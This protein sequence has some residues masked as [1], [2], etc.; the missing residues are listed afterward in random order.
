MD[1]R[2]PSG[3]TLLVLSTK[4]ATRFPKTRWKMQFF[5]QQAPSGGKSGQRR[6]KRPG[7]PSSSDKT[8]RLCLR[9]QLEGKEWLWSCK[10]PRELLCSP[11][12]FTLR[13]PA[14]HSWHPEEPDVEKIQQSFH[15]HKAHKGAQSEITFVIV[16]LK[17]L[18]K[19]HHH[20]KSRNSSAPGIAEICWGCGS[21]RYVNLDQHEM[22]LISTKCPLCPAMPLGSALLPPSEEPSAQGLAS[23]RLRCLMCSSAPQ[24]S[25]SCWERAAQ[26]KR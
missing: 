20:S 13:L 25:R 4:N 10:A 21:A 23:N 9:E 18:I 6:D 1:Q 17:H 3:S 16:P 11:G 8:Q 5:P 22:N 24:S 26:G 19:I 2:L 15:V 12:G 7:C 14:C